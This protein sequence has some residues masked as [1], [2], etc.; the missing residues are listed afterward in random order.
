M[1]KSPCGFLRF[2]QLGLQTAS[3][4]F[5]E[6]DSDWGMPQTDSSQAGAPLSSPQEA[7]L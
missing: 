2:P 3:C 4:F 7:P 5:E 1:L 6:A